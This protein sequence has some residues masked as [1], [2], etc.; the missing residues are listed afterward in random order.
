MAFTQ[1]DQDYPEGEDFID[2]LV[3][4]ENIVKVG[5]NDTSNTNDPV[6]NRMIE[7]RS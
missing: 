5:N 4:G 2:T 1:F 6:L 3:N 7:R